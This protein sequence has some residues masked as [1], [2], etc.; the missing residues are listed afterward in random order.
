MKVVIDTQILLRSIPKLAP[1]KIIYHAFDKKEFTWVLSNEILTE[2]AELV[3]KWYGVQTMSFV[4]SL[5]L[6][7][8]NH[9][10]FE[11]SYKWQLV[12]DDPDDNKFVDCAIGANA[13]YLVTDDKHIRKLLK[14]EHPFPPIEIVS[15]AEFKQILERRK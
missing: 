8:E 4:L 13:D 14:R 15:F 5:L 1:E 2:Y 6:E 10:L 3:S 12:E 9:Q 7:S 11:P